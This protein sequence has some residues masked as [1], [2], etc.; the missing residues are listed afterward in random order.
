[1]KL[2]TTEHQLVR[3]FSVTMVS[4]KHTFSIAPVSPTLLCEVHE[5]M[6]ESGHF[7]IIA[8]SETKCHCKH[9]LKEFEPIDLS[10]DCRQRS[11]RNR[12]IRIL[13]VFWRGGGQLTQIIRLVAF[14]NV[15]TKRAVV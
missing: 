12:I 6:N 2:K 7:R 9:R 1:M 5:I 14:Q 13:F 8:K 15:L 11:D 4:Q 3:K 10:F